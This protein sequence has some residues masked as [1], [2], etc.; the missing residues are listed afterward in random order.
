[1]SHRP[2]SFL[3]ICGL[4]AILTAPPAAA[5]NPVVVIETSLGSITAELDRRNAPVSVAN[6][7]AYAESGFYNGTVFHRVIRGFMIQGGGMTADLE[8]RETRAPIRNEATN[9]LSNDRGTLAMARTNVVDSATAQ[10]FINTVDNPGL[11]NRGTDPGSYGYAVFGRVID[12]LDVVDSIEGV[13]TGRRGPFN[14]VPNTAVEI[15]SVTVQ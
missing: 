15:L 14:D 1:M 7:L 4:A 3:V 5:Q 9:G 10:F 2:L 13:S 6:F 12:G 8:R 11:N